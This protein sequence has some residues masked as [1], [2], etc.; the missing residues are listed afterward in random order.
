MWVVSLVSHMWP[1]QKIN[2]KETNI[3]NLTV[4]VLKSMK[5]GG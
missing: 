5:P 4:Q 2:A 3:K 1:E